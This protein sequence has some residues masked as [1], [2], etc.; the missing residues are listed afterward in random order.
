MNGPKLLRMKERAEKM[1]LRSSERR[2]AC[3][4][5][6]SHIAKLRKAPT[7]AINAERTV[8]Q[9]D[10]GKEKDQGTPP[11]HP[12]HQR[13]VDAIFTTANNSSLDTH[14]Q[15]RGDTTDALMGDC[16]V[17]EVLIKRVMEKHKPSVPAELEKP[18]LSWEKQIE[19]GQKS[20][21]IKIGGERLKRC[22]ISAAEGWGLEDFGLQQNDP[23][24]HQYFRT[25]YDTNAVNKHPGNNY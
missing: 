19:L 10:K 16:T 13:V 23:S 7:Q 9:S 21:V 18:K 14:Y 3:R 8:N 24:V 17:E 25:S 6:N 1:P 4:K 5:I 12:A 20:I 2:Q 11:L 22:F 15:E